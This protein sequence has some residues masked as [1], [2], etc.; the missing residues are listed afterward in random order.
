MRVAILL[1]LAL[2]LLAL[3]S[4]AAEVPAH[5]P[6]PVPTPPPTPA[7]DAAAGDTFKAEERLSD[8]AVSVGGQRIDYQALTG[9]LVVHPK[10]WDDVPQNADKDAKGTQPEASMSYV[11]YLKK[12][13]RATERPIT[14]LY[15]GGPGSSTV[16]LHMGAFGPRRVV[17][18]DATHGGGAPYA[19]VNND[20]SLLDAS[21][22]VFIDAPGTGFGR[23]AGKDRDKAFYG[24]DGDAHAFAAFITQFLSSHGRW[25]SPKYLFGESYGTTRTAVLVALLE[26]DYAYSV[27]VNGVILLSQCL[28]FD[29]GPDGPG[30]TGSPEDNPGVELPYELALPTMAATAWYHHRLP[31]A[32]RELAPLVA[33]VE[34]FALGEYASALAAGSTLSAERRQ[35]VAARLHDYTGLPLDHILT[36]DLRINAGNFEQYLLGDGHNVARLDTRFTGP[37]FDPL[38]EREEYDAALAALAAPY[39]AAF[40][41]YVRRDLK[42]GD[43]RRFKLFADDVRNWNT[44][45]AAPNS[46][47]PAQGAS[48]NVLPDLAVAMK[49]NPNL[50]VQLNGGYYDLATPYFAAVFEL[51]QLP[52]QP[53]LARNIDMHFYPSGHM[54]YAHE[55]DLKALHAKIGKLALENDFLSGALSKAGLLSAKK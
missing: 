28:M 33:E 38:S 30:R 52:I 40:N 42:Y 24:I 49:Q 21:D 5:A 36:A 3:N 18:A 54:V 23:I 16:W 17:T 26:T 15:N 22:L 25:N 37:A 7:A 20:Y 51:R 13:A 12:G 19:I 55:P 2:S 27:D 50:K 11:A 6:S 1:P 44:E 8:G 32:A 31:G 39:T 14:F 53:E 43:G 45:H 48:L 9:T 47:P 29:G 34:D 35:A 4:V 46:A 10:G 41:D